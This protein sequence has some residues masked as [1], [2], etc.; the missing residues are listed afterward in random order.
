MAGHNK[1]TQIKRQ[2]GAEDQKRAKLFSMLGRTIAVES[3]QAQGNTASP[4]LRTAIEK[5]RKANMP[6][7]NIDR[8]VKRGIGGE[9]GSLEEIVM[10]GYGPGGVA[11]I[12]EAVTDSRNRT[13]HEVKHLLS[14]FGGSSANPG[15]ALWA[16]KKTE[17]GY[18]ATSKVE[19]NETD[20]EQLG[21]L[22]DALEEHEDVKSVTVN[23]E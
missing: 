6:N 18:T 23:A 21:T 7:E 16:F 10:E 15:A 14:K 8:A 11:L 22:V 19:L 17:E 12:I 5:A 9:A 20:L 3:R 2:K 4:A 1:W 13:T